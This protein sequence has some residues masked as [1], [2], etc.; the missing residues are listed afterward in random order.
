MDMNY[1]ELTLDVLGVGH[2][3]NL[4]LWNSGLPTIE[5]NTMILCHGFALILGPAGC[6]T[7][8]GYVSVGCELN[9]ALHK[10]TVSDSRETTHKGNH[11]QGGRPQ[12]I[13]VADNPPLLFGREIIGIDV[14]HGFREVGCI[15]VYFNEQRQNRCAKVDGRVRI[16][17]LSCQSQNIIPI[18]LYVF[19]EDKFFRF[20]FAGKWK[21]GTSKRLLDT[22]LTT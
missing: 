15:S 1:K 17:L 14:G 19:V 5:S 22:G 21:W 9:V 10:G 12:V 16:F 4:V 18:I 6:V 8:C 11:G 3:Y 7:P 13:A 2:A 20:G